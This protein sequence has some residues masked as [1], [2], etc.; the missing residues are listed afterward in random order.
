MSTRSIINLFFKTSKCQGEFILYEM[1]FF[2]LLP[3]P[4][5]NSSQE[6]DASFLKELCR[7]KHRD[8]LS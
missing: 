8:I 1:L 3:F 4:Y 6:E 7:N 2:S 5:N